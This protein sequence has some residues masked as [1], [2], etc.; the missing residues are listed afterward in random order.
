MDKKY[1]KPII[2][3]IGDKVILDPEVDD[4]SEH[5]RH[6]RHEFIKHNGIIGVITRINNNIYSLGKVP[7]IDKP[8]Q[9]I[10][11]VHF[12]FLGLCRFNDVDIKFPPF[13]MV[14]GEIMPFF[15]KDL[16]LVDDLLKY[17]ED[18]KDL[19]PVLLSTYNKNI[20]ETYNK[21]KI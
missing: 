12:Y 6:V 18:F 19:N 8:E 3:N 4:K 20:E 15:A 1:D 21:L 13:F 10:Y 2:F 16:L 14:D 9:L 11:G 17:N 5:F 7:C